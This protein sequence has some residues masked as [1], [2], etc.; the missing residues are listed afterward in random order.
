[1]PRYDAICPN[2]HETIDLVKSVNDPFPLCAKCG[3]QTS[4]LWSAAGNVA[5]IGDDIPGGIEMK[6]GICNPDGTP[7]R[8]YSKTEIKI[9]ANKR[10]LSW[11]DDTPGKPYNVKWDGRRTDGKHER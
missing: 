11:G 1:M 8:Y 6:H 10:G 9:A 2:E 5:V 7:K 3:E 4:I